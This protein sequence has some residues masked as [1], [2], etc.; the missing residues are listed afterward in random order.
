[1]DYVFE[2]SFFLFELETSQGY[3]RDCEALFLPIKSGEN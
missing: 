3:I 2:V 1:M